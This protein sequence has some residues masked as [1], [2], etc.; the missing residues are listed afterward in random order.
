MAI[1]NKTQLDMHGHNFIE[2]FPSSDVKLAALGV[3]VVQD[4]VVGFSSLAAQSGGRIMG[5]NQCEGTSLSIVS[6]PRSEY[7]RIRRRLIE[8]R[9]GS[10]WPRLTCFDSRVHGDSPDL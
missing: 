4:D 5:S 3:P 7:R 8:A 6:I 10:L 2:I 1:I 9:F